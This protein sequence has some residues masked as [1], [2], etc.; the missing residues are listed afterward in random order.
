M[1]KCPKGFLFFRFLICFV[2]LFLFVHYDRLLLMKTSLFRVFFVFGFAFHGVLEGT[3]GF[4]VFAK[5]ME[6]GMGPFNCWIVGYCLLDSL[7]LDT[8]M[9]LLIAN[10]TYCYP[11]DT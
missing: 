2:S 5:C 6:S 7:S 10:I 8:E 9:P 11:Y 4:H 3:D 1:F